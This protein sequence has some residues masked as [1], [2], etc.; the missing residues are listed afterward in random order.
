MIIELN[1]KQTEENLIKANI[2]LLI[3]DTLEQSQ[4]LEELV[5]SAPNILRGYSVF[6]D[7]LKA[8]KR[9]QNLDEAINFNSGKSCPPDELETINNACGHIT[10]DECWKLF[11]ESY[12]KAVVDGKV[13]ECSQVF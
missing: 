8:V 3:K 4:G 13:E 12:S 1:Q 6:R 7:I 10:C 5:A 2:N 11:I 9:G